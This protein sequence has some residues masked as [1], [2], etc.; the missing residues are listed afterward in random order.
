MNETSQKD[1]NNNFESRCLHVQKE[2]ELASIFKV[3]NLPRSNEILGHRK[4]PDGPLEDLREL[5]QKLLFPHQNNGVIIGQRTPLLNQKSKK[6]KKLGEAP[7]TYEVVRKRS[8]KTRRFQQTLVC[9][10]CNLC[11]SK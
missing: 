8:G 3:L 1:N 11:F 9:T 7:P 5:T 6:I 10:V 4:D 2:Q